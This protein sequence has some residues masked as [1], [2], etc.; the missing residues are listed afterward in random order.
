MNTLKLTCENPDE[1]LAGF[2]AGARIRVDFSTT[3]TGSYSN[4]T[5][6]ALVSGQRIYTYE[7]L[8]GISS[9]W[10]KVRF[11]DATGT[12]ANDYGAVFQVGDETAGLLCSLYDVRQL[13]YP[14]TTTGTSDDEL[15]L[16]L[17]REAST[18]IEGYTGRWLAPRPSSGERTVLFSP[19]YDSSRVVHGGKTLLIPWGIRSL[20]AI[21]YAVTDQPASGGTYTSITATDAIPVIGEI[22]WP[23]I[24][25]VLRLG[26]G[27][28]YCGLNTV[29]ITG[30]FGFSAV[31]AD[32][33]GV[34][35][36][37]VAQRYISRGQGGVSVAEGPA[38]QPYVLSGLTKFDWAILGRYRSIPA[39]D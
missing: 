16:D 21:G 9:T 20:S 1:V 18:A 25:L 15:I 26:A 33:Q 4:V 24:R 12:N 28:F 14:T 29:T 8:A 13:L 6:V 30:S 10:Y 34:A 37:M 35:V 5:Y 32:I 19:G 27:A 17:I 39:D 31:P 36:R 7:H 22:G 23:G 38:G 2:G 3:E 11:E